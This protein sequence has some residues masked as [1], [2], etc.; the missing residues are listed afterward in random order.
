MRLSLRNPNVATQS[1]FEAS[2]H[3]IAIDRRD[4]DA[5]KVS[6][7]LERRVERVGHRFGF[8]GVT[9]GKEIKVGPGRE[10]FL[11]L[12]SNH[13]GVTIEILI[14]GLNDGFKRA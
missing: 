10:K 8:R 5:S 6:Q 13:Q 1:A 7:R 9:I 3:G 2:A 12:P 14:Q 11:T 4:G